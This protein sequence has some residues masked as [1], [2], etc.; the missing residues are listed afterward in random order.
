MRFPSPLTRGVL[1]RR[2]KRFLADVELPDGQV[3]VAHCPNP[4][5]MHELAA[6][7]A[8]VWLQPA[9]GAGRK[10][11]WS[12]K[13]V[14]EPSSRALVLIDTLAAN[15]IVAEALAAGLLPAL[16]PIA[17]IRPEVRYGEISRAD[18]LLTDPQGRET[19]VE[20]KSVSL[21]RGGQAQFPDTPSA[22][23]ARH[24]ADLAAACGQG[25]RAAVVYLRVRSD[26]LPVAIAADID[27]KYARAA[28]AAADAGVAFMAL[29]CRVDPEGVQATGPVPLLPHR[30]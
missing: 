6:P 19:L 2:Y 9:T 5:A 25:R 28:M 24:M 22:R 1:L 15:R 26:D 14:R 23:A 3:A 27:P 12:W 7:G 21:G 17:A 8:E 18:F 10:L 29:G 30:P 4:G 13:L 20:V 16:G 11:A